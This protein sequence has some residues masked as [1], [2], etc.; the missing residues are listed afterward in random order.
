M[1][2][3]Y[4]LR[5]EPCEHCGRSDEE[6]HLGK[7][8]LGWTF[9]FRAYPDADPPVIDFASWRKQLETGTIWDEYGQ[10]AT[11]EDLAVLIEQKRSG[12]DDLYRDD[13]R[14]EDGNRFIPGEFS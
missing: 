12:R 5:H 10:Q 11:P 13:F 8:S 6:I 14:D 2:T 9:S 1:G 7:S 4:Y 3:N